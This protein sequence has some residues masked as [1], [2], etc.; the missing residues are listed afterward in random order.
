MCRAERLDGP[1]EVL[2]VVGGLANCFT[3]APK[4][5]EIISFVDFSN[6]QHTYNNTRKVSTYVT[7]NGPIQDDPKVVNLKHFDRSFDDNT[8]SLQ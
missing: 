3:N 6:A 4:M 5:A 7:R 8:E 2:K 1:T